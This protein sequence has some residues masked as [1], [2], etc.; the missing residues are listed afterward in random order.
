[1]AHDSNLGEWIEKLHHCCRAIIEE[2]EQISSDQGLAESRIL[3]NAVLA[4][5]C[6]EFGRLALANGLIENE[7]GGFL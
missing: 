3:L 1:M 6:D 7:A 2:F 5:A 4:A